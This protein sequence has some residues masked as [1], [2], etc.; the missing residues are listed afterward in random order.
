M[1][2]DFA[3][4]SV[5]IVTRK[6]PEKPMLAASLSLGYNSESTFR[7][8]Y[9]QPAGSLDFLGI[10]DGGR[11]LSDEVPTEYPLILGNRKPDGERVLGAE[12]EAQSSNLNSQMGVEPT[13]LLPNLSAS[14]FLGSRRR[15]TKPT[16]W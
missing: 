5:R 3:G 4:G 9:T 7:D 10:D 6:V 11:A 1:P 15:R 14:S 2:G 16:R 8:G 13:T 12:L